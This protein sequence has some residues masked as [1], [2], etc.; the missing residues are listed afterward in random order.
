MFKRVQENIRILISE[1]RR[2]ERV[3][4]GETT[5]GHMAEGR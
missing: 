1:G 4:E 3:R 2:Q 5:D